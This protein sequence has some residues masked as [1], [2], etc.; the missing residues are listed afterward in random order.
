MFISCT[1]A[2]MHA[3]GCWPGLADHSSTARPNRRSVASPHRGGSGSLRLGR[4][5]WDLQEL[6]PEEEE[7]RDGV[8]GMQ[9]AKR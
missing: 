8:K 1:L 5:S 9:R 4:E 3:G 7:G 2:A 6:E